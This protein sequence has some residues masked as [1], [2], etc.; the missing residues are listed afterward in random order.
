[1]TDS[2]QHSAKRICRIKT[3]LLNFLR[4][5]AYAVL[6]LLF[7]LPSRTEPHQVPDLYLS[8]VKGGPFAALPQRVFHTVRCAAQKPC[9]SVFHPL[10]SAAAPHLISR[11]L[12]SVSVRFPT[13][14]SLR[15]CIFHL[16]SVKKV[17]TVTRECQAPCPPVQ[18]QIPLPCIFPYPS[19]DFPDCPQRYPAGVFAAGAGIFFYSLDLKS[20]YPNCFTV[21]YSPFSCSSTMSGSFIPLNVFVFTMV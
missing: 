2:R 19:G 5:R 18:I 8:A 4:R 14:Y 21:S 1:M 20:S 11:R 17:S 9:S 10:L 16:K 7:A 3:R 13:D 6:P 12:R 15:H